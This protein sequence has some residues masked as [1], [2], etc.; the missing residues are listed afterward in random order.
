MSHHFD[1]NTCSLYIHWPFCPYRCSFCPFVALAGH[2]QFMS[3]YHKALL[4]EI[5]LY[6]QRLD[7]K[8]VLKTIFFGGGTPSTYPED[9][10]LDM[11]AKLK[12][13]FDICDQAEVSIEVNPGTVDEQKL[14]FFKKVGINRLSIGVQSLKDP[15]LK[16]LNRL[17]SSKD[18]LGLLGVAEQYFENI[19]VDLILGL[20]GV[21]KR[22]WEELLQ[23]VVSWPLKHISIYFL[24]IHSNTRLKFQI[25]QKK[26]ELPSDAYVVDSYHWSVRF[27]K[28]YGFAQYET[29]NFAQR[30]YE[31]KHN[32]VYWERRPYKGFGLGACSFD[33]KVRFE[34]KKNLI[35]YLDCLK[36]EKDCTALKEV[37]N[38]QQV[39]LEKIMLGLRRSSGISVKFLFENVSQEKKRRLQ[40]IIRGLKSNEYIQQVGDNLLLTVKGF[41]LQNDI[42][43]RLS[44]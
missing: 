17:Q 31:C 6:A 2:D 40:E 21:R 44:L 5:D 19:S 36:D 23:K 15:V 14:A 9:L 18:V 3:Q 30:G 26:V 12:E 32:L 39:R 35:D 43:V 16:R 34:N 20:P 29:S 38:E 11:F 1:A 22:E 27:L 42:A 24:T 7:S 28:R 4:T 37:L 8:P 41:V 25:Q 33:G 10:L 13:K